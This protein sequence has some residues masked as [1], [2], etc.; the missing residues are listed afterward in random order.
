M[1][2]E[3]VSSVEEA[4]A[5]IVEI[6]DYDTPDWLSEE[7]IETLV[8]TYRENQLPSHTF[9]DG[10]LIRDGGTG[11][12]SAPYNWNERIGR[13]D[14]YTEINVEGLEEA[15]N[16]GWTG[17]G[18]T[19]AIVEGSFVDGG[20]GDIVKGITTAVAPD[21][22]KVEVTATGINYFSSA[23]T[24]NADVV[25]ISAGVNHWALSNYCNQ[26]LNPQVCVARET[27]NVSAAW[28]NDIASVTDLADK[29]VVISAG[30]DALP[31]TFATNGDAYISYDEVRN[32]DVTVLANLADEFEGKT[33][34]VVALEGHEIASYSNRAGDA[35]DHGL[36]PQ[37]ETDHTFTKMMKEHHMQHQEYQDQQR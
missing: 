36:Y 21:S 29:V 9:A 34:V 14:A 30:N 22:T 32:G 6:G 4:V 31:N 19:I 35:A 18:T 27:V 20:H 1:L 33:I 17:A 8:T 10:T 7:A 3:N 2:S 16:N 12:R 28:L 23:A 25:N 24:V 37:T 11:V 26:F 13:T 15:H 5:L